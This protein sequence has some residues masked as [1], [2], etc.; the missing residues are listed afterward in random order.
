MNATTMIT[1]T[2]RGRLRDILRELKLSRRMKRDE[3]AAIARQLRAARVV[4]SEEV[5]CNI[6]T[7]NSQVVLRDLDTHERLVCTL[8]YPD[9]IRMFSDKL[10][11]TSPAG[12][13]LLGR[14]V[15]QI[16]R[17]KLGPRLRRYRIEKVSYQPEAAGDFDL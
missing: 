14:C 6:V 11:I 3:L 13:A 15:G 8:A 4:L 1:Q 2:D 16:V 12:L 7:M 9:A 5:P 10:S 17:W